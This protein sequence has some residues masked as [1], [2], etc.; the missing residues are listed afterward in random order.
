MTACRGSDPG[1]HNGEPTSLR[2]PT[3]PSRS[4][5]RVIQVPLRRAA[6]VAVALTLA[7]ALFAVGPAASAA[8]KGPPPPRGTTTT[9]SLPTT[10][11]SSTTTTSTTSTTTSTTT[12]APTTTTTTTTT[13]LPSSQPVTGGYD[14]SWPQ[15]S[16]TL[17]GD[18]TFAVVGVSDGRAFS[19]NPCLHAQY[20][21]AAG[22]PRP[23]ALY[24][25]TG[26]PG[27][28]SVHWTEPG[29]KS[30]NGASSDSGCA[31]N[32]GWNAASHAFDYA[33]AQTGAAAQAAWWLDVETGNSWS[34][35]VSL[36][37][38]DIHGMVDFFASRSV[39]V[40]V[41]STRFQWNQITGGLALAVPN[42]LAGA[43]ST[44]Q[45]V[46]WCSTASSFSGG[47]VAMVQYATSTID[48]DVA[49]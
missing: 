15:C 10:T 6:P 47:P 38:A 46:N 29:P 19:D 21:W 26:N 3:A 27:K 41:Y 14:V 2:G 36:N 32:Y 43:T 7:G 5:V 33:Q 45:A 42:W 11:S 13:T 9:T 4:D 17:P 22:A 18:A 20:T 30:C 48:T 35:T 44:S 25:N 24:M 40:G 39:T 28:Q 34:T 16:S 23:P 1:T 37:S 49:C 12:T 8:R 31:Y